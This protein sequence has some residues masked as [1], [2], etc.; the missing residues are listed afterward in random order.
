MFPKAHAAAYVMMAWRVAYCK[1]FYP[2]EYY[3]AY[4]S[5]RAKAFDYEKMAMGRD[6]LAYYIKEYRKK[7]ELKTITGPEEEE[8]KD[9][10][11]AEEMYARGFDFMPVDIYKAK[12]RDFQ[13]FNGKI[14]PSLKV[15]DKVGEVAGESIEIAAS[16]GNKFLSKE[17]LMKRAKVG[18]TVIEKLSEIHALDGLTES[19]QLTLFDFN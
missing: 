3:C 6:K 15:I 9:M 4:F 13:I 16:A 18:Q 12:A 2:L 17:D 1:I 19:N 7:A 14:M 5:I 8:L 11:L 10:R